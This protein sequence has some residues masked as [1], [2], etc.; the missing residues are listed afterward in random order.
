MACLHQF[1]ETSVDRGPAGPSSPAAR[2]TAPLSQATSVGPALP[3]RWRWSDGRLPPR[4][5][6]TTRLRIGWTSGPGRRTAS[7]SRR[8]SAPNSL[9]GWSPRPVI[10]ASASASWRRSSPN[11]PRSRKTAAGS[12]STIAPL[13]L[14]SRL[15]SSFDQRIAAGS[16]VCR[17]RRPPSVNAPTS[18][19]I[20]T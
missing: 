19:W 7:G 11:R 3:S 9:I 12:R 1:G 13:A 20:A 10:V 8:V 4:P 5:A 18:R 16:A 2:A 14:P 15:I 17:A 6:A